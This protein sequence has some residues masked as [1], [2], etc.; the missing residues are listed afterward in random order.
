MIEIRVTKTYEV[1]GQEL[2]TAF[3]K[4][5]E[6]AESPEEFHREAIENLL[7]SDPRHLLA[8]VDEDVDID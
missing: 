6:E 8:L 4:E 1:D 3:P 7:G 5:F 2:A